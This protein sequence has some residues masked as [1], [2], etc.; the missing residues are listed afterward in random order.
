MLSSL[1]SHEELLATGELVK[2]EK[3]MGSAI[4]VSHQWVSDRHPDPAGRQ[5]RILQDA[6]ANILSGRSKITVPPVVEIFDGL[7]PVPTAAQLGAKSLFIWYDYFSCPQANMANRRSAIN[8]I[9]AYVVRCDYFMVL[10]PALK[11]E[12]PD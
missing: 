8:S 3:S 12:P 10:S 2:F 11:H 1:K 6:L 5:F 4:F 7:V 9:H